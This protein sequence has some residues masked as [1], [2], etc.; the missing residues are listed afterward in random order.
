MEIG[1]RIGDTGRIR[2]AV[3][4]TVTPRPET[5]NVAF[6]QMLF[7]YATH[8]TTTQ[9]EFRLRARSKTNNSPF[10]TWRITNGLVTIEEVE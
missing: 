9:I 8:N 4:V 1:R 2:Q 10:S 6:E 5:G 3:L 7:V